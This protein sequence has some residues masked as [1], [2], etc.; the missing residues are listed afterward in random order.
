[1]R[2][3]LGVFLTWIFITMAGPDLIYGDTIGPDIEVTTKNASYVE[4]EN[5][6]YKDMSSA[7]ISINVTEK[8]MADTGISY[9]YME[10]DGEIHDLYTK[11]DGA[12]QYEY[13]FYIS[14]Y[15]NDGENKHIT[16]YA[17]DKSGN[18]K[19][20]EVY[21]LVD[22]IAPSFS[23]AYF[24]ENEI[25]IY[26]TYEIPE[27]VE[28]DYIVIGLKEGVEDSFKINGVDDVSGLASVEYYVELEGQEYA[29]GDVP[30]TS[31]S[32]IT[33]NK[34]EIMDIPSDIKGRI[35]FRLHDNVGNISN[36]MVTKSILIESEEQFKK[37]ASID[38]SLPSTDNRD[39]YGN[40]LY[41]SEVDINASLSESYGGIEDGTYEIYEEGKLI[42]SGSLNL[43]NRSYTGNILKDCK[44]SLKYTNEA[45]E[46][47]INIKLIGKAGFELEKTVKFGIDKTAPTVAM[48]ITGGQHD[49]E[50][51]EYYN[52][53]VVIG[54][55][56][57]DRNLDTDRIMFTSNGNRV[58]IGD[59]TSNGNEASG[60]VSIAEDG[61]YDIN[62]YVVDRADNESESLHIG[63]VIDKT[64]PIIQ[65]TYL[66]NDEGIYINH[67]RT[68][69]V[70]IIDD[71][72]EPG[73]I[74]VLND[75][76]SQYSINTDYG[77]SILFDTDGLYS[78]HINA[79]DRAGNQAVTYIEPGFVVDKTLPGIFIDGVDEGV[80]YNGTISGTITISDTNLDANN[81][82]TSLTFLD[83]NRKIELPIAKYGD[84]VVF[85]INDLPYTREYNGNYKV[86]ATAIDLA[87][88]TYS[89]DVSFTVN[90][91]GSWYE[92]S[93]N[94]DEYKG[95]YLND[96]SGIHIYE[97][98]VDQLDENQIE[99]SYN[100]EIVKLDAHE[101]TCSSRYIDNCYVYDYCIEDS[102]FTKDG[103]YRIIASSVD[104]AGNVNI[105]SSKDNL[106]NIGF[107]VDRTSP[108]IMGLNLA[109]GQRIKEKQVP[110]EF[111]IRDNTYLSNVI[112]SLNEE[113]IAEYSEDF[114]DKYLFFM[115]ETK[116]PQSIKVIATDNAG[117]TTCMEVRD[118]MIKTTFAYKM[119]ND[120][121]VPLGVFLDIIGVIGLIYT[122]RKRL[123]V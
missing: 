16:I 57:T 60:N 7:E 44:S 66:D 110:I 113:I 24:G 5:S 93:S 32:S 34:L 20:S 96:V 121:N 58:D 50:Y 81:I 19:S 30:V 106:G 104:R 38:I 122:R 55:K 28:Q 91:F 37:N 115:Y 89:D 101:Y 83:D 61:H 40:Y 120:Y 76:S 2:G 80:S 109:D 94:V 59:I 64:G 29:E 52:T 95:R 97:Y 14:S 90:R 21:I 73:R 82:N 1:M 22:N 100:G 31:T 98:N 79:K 85:S 17:E 6:Y 71:N 62:M 12:D 114:P 78:Y 4:G 41:N 111:Y 25:T 74:E 36:W 23:K 45:G 107:A 72:P 103:N 116:S 84:K 112:I 88:N 117:N 63:F 48:S 70:E 43:E 49:A 11:D 15:V 67:G 26:D 99:I 56:V 69:I 123:L 39:A 86:E 35:W 118:I 75:A 77:L 87:G 13:E 54:F 33:N 102:V 53:D 8:R 108:M 51:L 46:I 68:A 18:T 92:I 27:L 3:K 42:K 10:M 105:S 9:V 119:L 47:T 65:V